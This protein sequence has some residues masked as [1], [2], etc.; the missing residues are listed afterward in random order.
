[1]AGSL[2]L[3]TLDHPA[4]GL[5]LSGG[6]FG[7]GHAFGLYS[8]GSG[9]VS[10]FGSLFVSSSPGYR[11]NTEFHQINSFDKTVFPLLGGTA[12]V[13]FQVYSEDSGSPGYLD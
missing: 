8:L 11:D 12:S 3:T 10:G 7:A 9:P 13:R 6:S 1:M 5:T 4:S 2:N